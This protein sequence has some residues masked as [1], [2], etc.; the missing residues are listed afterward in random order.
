[1]RRQSAPI[2]RIALI[3]KPVDAG[4]RIGQRRQRQRIDHRQGGKLESRYECLEKI[5]VM[6][7][8]IVTKHEPCAGGQAIDFAQRGVKAELALEM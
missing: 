1:M 2:E 6:P 5:Q 4:A 3:A 7:E 8:D